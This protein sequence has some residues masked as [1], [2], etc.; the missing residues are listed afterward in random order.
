MQTS[1]RIAKQHRVFEEAVPYFLMSLAPSLTM[2]R[3]YQARKKLQ[4]T[5]SEYYTA[6][7][8]LSDP[9]ASTLTVNR[10]NELRKYGFT[11]NEIGLLESILPVVST[12]NAI[13]TL[14]WL[15]LYIL[16]NQ[17]LVDELREEIAA[18]IEMSLSASTGVRTIIMNISKFESDLPLLVSCYREALRLCNH[19]VCNRR[20]MEDLSIKDET[21]R[22]YLL[23]KGVDVQL[24][25]GVT[26]RAT[27]VWGSDADQ[28]RANRFG[29]PA[30]KPSD[31]DRTRK[32]AYMPFGGGRH[33]CPG[34]NFAFAEIVSCAAVLLLGFDIEASKMEFGDMR[35]R[36]PRL[37][38]GT[39]KPVNG[40]EGLGAKINAREE[41]ANVAWKFRA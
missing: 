12:L 14:Y 20:I 38:S 18:S 19:T 32:I 40:G 1:E 6:E 7:Y 37:S 39:V 23:K 16:P 26:Q 4:A 3:S 13:P 35:M 22:T 24:P 30:S 21:G 8:H 2:P 34:R 25:A 17:S 9:T 36:G 11:G 29:P 5:M 27:N 31:A 33:L 28:F 41:F 15:L 10:A